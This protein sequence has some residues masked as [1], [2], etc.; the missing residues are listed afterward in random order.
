MSM[1]VWKRHSLK[2]RILRL[3][4]IKHVEE[5]TLKYF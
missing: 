4:V 5:S 3:D 2:S 1:V